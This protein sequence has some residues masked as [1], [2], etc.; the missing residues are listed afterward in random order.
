M[1]AANIGETL[2]I[3]VTR[4]I[5]GRRRRIPGEYLQPPHLTPAPPTPPRPNI[6]SPQIRSRPT[7]TLLPWRGPCCLEA[8]ANEMDFESFSLRIHPKITQNI[9]TLD[10]ILRSGQLAP[11]ISSMTQRLSNCANQRKV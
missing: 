2:I 10:I 9:A 5:P 8:R 7:I 6:G 11:G 1:P 3:C 4:R